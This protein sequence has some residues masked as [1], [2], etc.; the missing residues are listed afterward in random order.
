MASL[1]YG[2]GLRLTECLNLRV[3]DID[4]AGDE[5]TVRDGKGGKDRLTV[6]PGSLKTRPQE[7]LQLSSRIHKT[8]LA[9][10]W[11]RPDAYAL[12]R[13]Y[14]SASAEWWWQWVFPQE[15]RWKNRN[16]GEEVRHCA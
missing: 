3:Q 2:S 6:L 4:F 10:G 7:H 8:D 11:G 14:P 15:N 13:N 12:A 5:I 1:L 16:T 9:D